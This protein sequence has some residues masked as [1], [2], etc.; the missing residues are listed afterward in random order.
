MTPNFSNHRPKL[1]PR[2]V[3]QE[4]KTKHPG[5]PF[6]KKKNDFRKPFRQNKK[7]IER[8]SNPEMASSKKEE[9][10]M[11]RKA[12]VPVFKRPEKRKTLMISKKLSSPTE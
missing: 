2:E 12:P 1:S 4:P 5:L 7:P 9:R 3:L 6:L 11:E 10:K 8:K